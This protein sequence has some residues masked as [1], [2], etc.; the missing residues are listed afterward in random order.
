MYYV[1]SG[2]GDLTM[3]GVKSEVGPG[4]AILTR[5]GSSHGL[6]QTGSE[7]LVT[8]IVTGKRHNPRRQTE[9]ARRFTGAVH[10]PRH[11]APLFHHAGIDQPC[12]QCLKKSTANPRLWGRYPCAGGASPHSATG[13]STR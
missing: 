3:N 2:T 1:I 7:G 13:I 10:C 11:A 8:S 5:L 12:P 9:F 4:T 6:R